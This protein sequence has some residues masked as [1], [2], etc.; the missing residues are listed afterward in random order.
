MQGSVSLRYRTRLG[1][2][3]ISINT[4]ALVNILRIHPTLS[5]R[6]RVVSNTWDLTFTLLLGRNY[7]PKI[8]ITLRRFLDQVM[9]IRLVLYRL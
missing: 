4:P 6:Y 9:A 1:L 2:D 5:R 3:A 7:P 8:P